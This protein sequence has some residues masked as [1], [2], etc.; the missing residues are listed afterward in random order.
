MKLL[1]NARMAALPEREA[2]LAPAE[3]ESKHAA[4]RA[5]ASQLGFQFGGPEGLAARLAAS[6]G[7]ERFRLEGAVPPAWLDG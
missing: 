2:R 3:A 1:G 5:Y 7:A 6:G 4:C